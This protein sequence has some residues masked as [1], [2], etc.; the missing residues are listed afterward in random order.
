[1]YMFM[2]DDLRKVSQG[3][4]TIN[5]FRFTLRVQQLKYEI[6]F[7]ERSFDIERVCHD[8]MRNDIYIY[9]NI[10]AIYTKKNKLR[11]T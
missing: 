6:N 1:M 4:M 9:I 5:K 3:Q 2:K 11:L 8:L 10:R 7:P